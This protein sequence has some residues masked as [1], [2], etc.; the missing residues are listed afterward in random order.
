MNSQ[1]IDTSTNIL[2]HHSHQTKIAGVK[3]NW[4]LERGKKN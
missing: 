1:V 4:Y 3:Y 2:Q